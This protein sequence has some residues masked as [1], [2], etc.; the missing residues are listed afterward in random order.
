MSLS[1]LFPIKFFEFLAIFFG[2]GCSCYVHMFHVNK[3]LKVI[4]SHL[5]KSMEIRSLVMIQNVRTITVQNESV[6]IKK[7]TVSFNHKPFIIMKCL[8]KATMTRSRV[9]SRFNEMK[10]ETRSELMRV[11]IKNRKLFVWDCYV[12]QREY[13]SYLNVKNVSNKKRFGE[14]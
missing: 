10:S 1:N 7:K 12:R 13:F 2:W 6:L 5:L 3:W 9:K 8:R 14:L 4:L 11:N